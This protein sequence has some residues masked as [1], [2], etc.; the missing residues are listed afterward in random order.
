MPKIFWLLFAVAPFNVFCQ[1]TDD[2]SDGDFTTNPVW[3]GDNSTHWII[4]SGQLRS[5]SLTPSST[6]YITTPSSLATVAQWTFSIHL[7]FNTSGA[8][9]VDV[10]LTSE[11]AN[12][13][14]ASNNGYFVRIGGTNDEVSFWKM[15]G[16]VPSLLID[17]I[18]GVTNTSNNLMRISVT[19]DASHVW[20]L[21]RDV[22]ITGTYF[23]EGTTLDATF[24]HT[25]FFGIRITQSTSSFHTKHHFDDFSIGDLITDTSPPNLINVTLISDREVEVLFSSVSLSEWSGNTL[26]I[27]MRYKEG[28]NSIE[29]LGACCAGLRW[30]Q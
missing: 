20:T 1:V 5:N 17:G 4:S 27:L 6:F 15:T 9:Y 13:T 10:Y 23:T 30:A 24:L 14:S 29:H 12:L 16:G 26:S 28:L 18:N 21:Q 19:R 11:E 22:G 25:S 7:Q 2:F 8:N 3:T